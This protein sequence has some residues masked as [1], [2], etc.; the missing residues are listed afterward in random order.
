MNADK[1]V[2]RTFVLD[3]ETAE[4]LDYCAA[5]MGRSRSEFLRA[6]VAEP[7]ADLAGLL[8]RV[9]ESPTAADLADLAAAGLAVVERRAGPQVSKLIGLKG[10]NSDE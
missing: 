2:R 1:W 10:G 9:P 5:R 8:R 3:L 6:V 7:A 4:S